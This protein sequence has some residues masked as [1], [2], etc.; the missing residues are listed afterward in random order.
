[1]YQSVKSKGGMVLGIALQGD[2]V[3]SVQDFQER[4]KTSYPIA[5]DT[6]N[7]FGK[8]I[9][10]IPLTIVVDRK[11]TIREVHDGFDAKTTV[12]LK[13]PYLKLLSK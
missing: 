8:F 13:G 4:N 11:G 10:G 3:S 5:M 1:V 2:S 7:K 6:Q 9:E 12:Q